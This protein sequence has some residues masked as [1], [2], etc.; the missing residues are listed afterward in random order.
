VCVQ[1]GDSDKRSFK[2]ISHTPESIDTWLN[3]L[4]KTAKGNIAVAVELSKGPI[5]YAL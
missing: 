3:E 1:I 4:H 5:V 2:V